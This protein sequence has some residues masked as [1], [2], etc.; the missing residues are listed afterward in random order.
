M[1]KIK[2]LSFLLLLSLSLSLTPTSELSAQCPMCK[3][4]AEKNLDGGGTAGAGLNKGIM[5]MLAMPYLLVG[6]MGY[7]WYIN[8]RKEEELLD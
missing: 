5:Y 6:A 4:S 3:M 2:K 1:D 7:V 8:R